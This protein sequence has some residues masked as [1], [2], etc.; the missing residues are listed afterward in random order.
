[1]LRNAN[2]SRG[3]ASVPLLPNP[4]WFHSN[5]SWL[6]SNKNPWMKWLRRV[7]IFSWDWTLLS[8]ISYASTEI[9]LELMIRI[10]WSF[11]YCS[12]WYNDMMACKFLIQSLGNF[13]FKNTKQGKLLCSTLPIPIPEPFTHTYKFKPIAIFYIVS[14]FKRQCLRRK[15][16]LLISPGHSHTHSSFQSPLIVVAK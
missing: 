2:T 12:L 5:S 11:A 9:S 13:H 1:M 6:I 3:D 4:S 15:F 8:F 10:A 14:L 7:E 16:G